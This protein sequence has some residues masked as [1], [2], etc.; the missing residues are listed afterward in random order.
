MTLER[1]E[2]QIRTYKEAWMA[3][4]LT[5][6][7]E[8]IIERCWQDWKSSREE[9]ILEGSDYF[10][11]SRCVGNKGGEEDVL[12]WF[13]K[14]QDQIQEIKG[15]SKEGQGRWLMWNVVRSM[16]W[17]LMDK[18][19]FGDWLESESDVEKRRWINWLKMGLEEVK[20]DLFKEDY[21]EAFRK[22]QA[23]IDSEN[24]KGLWNDPRSDNSEEESMKNKEKNKRI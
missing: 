19:L 24:W 22:I 21:D 5:G 10:L 23:R 13:F 6:K 2:R 4:I 12:R 20:N 8:T 7:N 11:W 17:D 3:A 16:R 1:K 15:Y 9:K 14:R 18:I